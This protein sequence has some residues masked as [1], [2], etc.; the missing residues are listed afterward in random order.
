M[1]SRALLT[2]LSF[3]AALLLLSC[4]SGETID[5]SIEKLG[6]A[7]GPVGPIQRTADAPPPAEEPD[8]K[9]ARAVHEGVVAERIHVPNYTYLRLSLPDGREAWAAVPKVEIEVGTKAR[10]VESLVMHEFRSP[11]LDR[12]F[13]AIVFGTLEG[14]EAPMR[15]AGSA[16][17]VGAREPPLPPGHPPI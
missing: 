6:R 16:D 3:L 17:D 1:T 5:P 14:A 4:K 7:T 12:T 15:D 2:S 9:D 10:V 11:T 8:G 13:E